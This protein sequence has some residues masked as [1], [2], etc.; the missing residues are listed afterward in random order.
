MKK[1]VISFKEKKPVFEIEFVSNRVTPCNGLDDKHLDQG[2]PLNVFGLVEHRFG[3][4]AFLPQESP[5][6]EIRYNDSRMRCI[7][8]TVHV[9]SDYT[10]KIPNKFRSRLH[11]G[12]EVAVSVDAQGRLI[13]TPIEQ[14]RALLQE[15]FGMW[16]DRTD[17]PTDGVE[18]VDYI[19][20]GRRL[21]D[22]GL[23]E[24]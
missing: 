6:Y 8:V 14:M 5:P 21:D 24:K 3:G 23:R 17:I 13:I 9:S 19:R 11:A 18:Y 2:P 16:A 20:R 22:L 7:M 1:I 10:V 12:Q 4:V 15:T